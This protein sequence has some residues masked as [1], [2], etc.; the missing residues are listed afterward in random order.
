MI[1]D[2][3]RIWKEQ[4]KCF[5]GFYKII[6]NVSYDLLPLRV[7][8]NTR[9]KNK[10]SFD[11]GNNKKS[12]QNRNMLVVYRNAEPIPK[13]ST[14]LMSVSLLEIGKALFV[15]C[16]FFSRAINQWYPVFFT[17]GSSSKVEVFWKTFHWNSN[18]NLIS[19][20]LNFRR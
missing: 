17:L 5:E 19:F 14:M 12:N 20:W 15:C 18:L 7:H 10:I 11:L 4:R 9:K 2:T 16:L 3:C 1:E 6:I 13:Q 8:Q